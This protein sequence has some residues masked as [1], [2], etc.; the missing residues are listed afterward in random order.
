MSENLF[1]VLWTANSKQVTV[2]I[3]NSYN[4]VKFEKKW[5][6]WL[7]IKVLWVN[8]NLPDTALDNLYLTI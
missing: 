7:Q 4:T 2:N 1:I 3:Y 6:I 8:T 5:K